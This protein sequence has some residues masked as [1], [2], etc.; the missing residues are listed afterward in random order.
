METRRLQV[1]IELELSTA[2][3]DIFFLSCHGDSRSTLVLVIFLSML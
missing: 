1:P 3:T 2:R